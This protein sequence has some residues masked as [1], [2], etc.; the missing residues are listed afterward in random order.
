LQEVVEDLDD[1]VDLRL[2]KTWENAQPEC[3]VHDKV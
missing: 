2:S 1:V 3:V